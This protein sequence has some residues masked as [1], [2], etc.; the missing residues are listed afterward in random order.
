VVIKAPCN[1][2]M[3]DWDA[4]WSFA[5]DYL[6]T[7]DELFQTGAVADSGGYSNPT[8]DALIAQ[9]LSNSNLQY[10]YNW[11]DYLAKQLPVLWQPN[12]DFQLTEIAS[13]LKGVTPQ[14]PTLSLT[15]EYWYF[16]K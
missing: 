2:D 10:F 6:P 3:G 11:Q 14:S 7:G 8:N 5:P 12:A 16:V 13:T 4:G 15:P 9:T 1:W